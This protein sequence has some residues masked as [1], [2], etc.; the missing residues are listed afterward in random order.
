MKK[1][2]LLFLSLT[3]QACMLPSFTGLSIED[4]VVGPGEVAELGDTVKVHYVGSLQDG[5]VFDS[6][7]E[8][9]HSFEFVLGAGQVIEG[10]DKGV[11]GM[12]VGGSRRLTIPSDMAYGDQGIPGVIPG[13]ATLIFEVELLEVL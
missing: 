7:R 8:R 10:W 11:L 6:S 4:L 12:K 5:T 1:L 9:E 13:G 2:L 3:F